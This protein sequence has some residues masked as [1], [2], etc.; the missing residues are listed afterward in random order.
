[1]KKLFRLASVVLFTS[2][3]FVAC[4]QKEV[5]VSASG[6]KNLTD[7]ASYVMGYTQA[8]QMKTQGVEINPEVFAIAIQQ[9]LSGD[10][11]SL[12]TQE[13]MQKTM[14]S[15]QEMM[16]QKQMAE[17]N[18]IAEPNKKA[19]E[20]FLAK[21]KEEKN[22]ETTPSGLQYRV[23]KE[24]KGIKPSSADD[25]VR[26]NYSL[27]VLKSDGS[28]SEPIENTFI[29]E[30][31]PTISVLNG[32]ISGVVEG[33]CLMNQ[34]SIYEFWIHPD[35]AYGNQHSEAIPAGSL[36]Q[37]RIELVEVLPSK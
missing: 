5:K 18:K 7:S 8:M 4:S 17:L 13:Q 1:M 36:L 25:R 9:V 33:F 15:Y 26:F 11:T 6:L 31:D 24:G 28:F 12:L 29:R 22:V 10:T 35:L 23:E 32:L 37:F 27:T 16:M 19:A 20:A 2:I 30:G 3:T 21:N 34:G 14:Q